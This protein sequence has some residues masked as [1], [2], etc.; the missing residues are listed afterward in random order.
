MF[1]DKP[2][3]SI[4]LFSWI[5]LSAKTALLYADTHPIQ[6]SDRK[7]LWELGLSGNAA[8][9]PIYRGSDDE[10]IYALPLPYFIYRGR[11]FQSDRDGVRGIFYS[12]DHIETTL[13]GWGNPPVDDD[14]TAREGMGDLDALFE[15]G[16][17]LKWYPFKRHP[18]KRFYL[19]TAARSIFSIGVPDDLRTH[20]RGHRATA[21]F[22]FRDDALAGSLLWR[23]GIS[24]GVDFTDRQ[25]NDFLYGVPDRYA[26]KLR[27][28]YTAKGGYAGAMAAI[29]LIRRF[30][31]SLS[32]ALYTR[33]DNISGAVYESSPLVETSNNFTVAASFIWKLKESMKPAPSIK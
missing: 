3:Y 30:T 21:T 2:Y 25:Y 10:K 7:P 33:I 9:I 29:Y 32:L 11:L 19:Q 12:S 24:L 26:N 4:I 28:A 20:H 17:A 14:G 8:S 31:D 15:L 13:S 1:K 16:P 6:P 27:P 23:W 5:I 18:H 22:Y